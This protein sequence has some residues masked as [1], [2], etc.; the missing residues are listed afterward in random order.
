M[1]TVT[2]QVAASAD[3]AYESGS[4]DV[5]T[6]YEHNHITVTPRYIFQRWQLNVPQGATISSATVEV[7]C[8]DGSYDDAHWDI[9]GEDADNASEASAG[10]DNYDVT[11]RDKTTAKVDWDEDSTGSGWVSPSDITAIVQ[12]VVNRAGWSSG[13]YFALIWE[14]QANIDFDVRHYDY[15]GNA[16]GA[17]LSVTYTTGAGVTQAMHHYRTRRA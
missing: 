10:A 4:G 5:N 3:D 11:G 17:K 9:Q 12:E 16:H 1:P 8:H 13:N 15:S 7:Y 14:S 2:P 6:T